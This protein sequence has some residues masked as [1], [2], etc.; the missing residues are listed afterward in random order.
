MQFNPFHRLGEALQAAGDQNPETKTRQGAT[1]FASGSVDEIPAPENKADEY[2]LFRT[3]PFINASLHQF[4][5]DVTEPGYRVESDNDETADW[6]NDEFL[7]EAGVIAG[8]RGQDFEDILYQSVIQHQA[9]G[10]VLVEKVKDDPSSSNPVYTGFM[11]I[12]P[13]SVKLVTE[14]NRPILIDPEATDRDEVVLTKRGEAAAYLQYHEGS[15][16]GQR[17]AFRDRGVVALSLNDVIKVSRSPIPGEVW[18][19]SVIHSVA[20]LARGMKQIIRDNEKAIQT[21]AYGIWSV[22]FGT[23][24]LDF[25]E[26]AEPELIEWSEEDQTD[27][28]EHKIGSEMGP[29]DVIGH[30]G[31]IEFDKFEGELADGLIDIIELYTK[32]I[33]TALPTPLYAVGFESNI[34]QFVTEQQETRYDKKLREMR[35][36]LAQAFEPALEEI[37]E[38]QGLSTEGLT[39]RIEPEEDESPVMALDD[40][41]MERLNMFTTSLADI[42][43]NGG[44]TTFLDEES[45][46][47]L[48]LQ[49]PS[50]AIADTDIQEMALGEGNGQVQAQFAEGQPPPEQAATDGGEPDG[51][52]DADSDGEGS[53]E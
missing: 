42:Y 31:T 16:L 11:H 15:I 2:K 44:A 10:D 5:S 49:L 21:K 1:S 3:T 12:R 37:A 40:D 28:L 35:E 19:E 50:D 45:L 18:G 7:P 43:G 27:F 24:V 52:G 17:G 39:L 33:I 36:T 25:G 20:D 13:E 38:Q 53:S 9:A 26:Y 47:E 30:D 48:I 4:A 8:E 23:E 46:A 51:G 6:F 41:D 34:N 22:A 29:G 14:E 32:L